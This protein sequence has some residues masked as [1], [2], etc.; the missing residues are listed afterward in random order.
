MMSTPLRDQI[1]VAVVRRVDDR[2]AAEF[3]VGLRGSK[4]T[5]TGCSEFPGGKISP[6]EPVFAAAE[7]ECVEETGIQVRA[8]ET[9]TVTQ[10]DYDFGRLELHFVL[11]EPLREAVPRVPFEWVPAAE[12][13]TRQFPTANRD[14]LERLLA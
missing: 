5:L 8:V 1:A 3:L 4:Q 14:V 12:L 10:H 11:C 7:R 2:G 6:G 13:A 9:L